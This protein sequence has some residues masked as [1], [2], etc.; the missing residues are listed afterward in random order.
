MLKIRSTAFNDGERIPKKYT[1]DGEDISPPLIWEDIPEGTVTLALI[2][3]DPD[4]P[5][6]TW[7]HWLIFNIPPELNG[8]PESVEKVGELENGI[9]QGFND[10]G[11]I[12]YGGPCPPF[13]VHRYFF[14]LYALDTSL[15]LEPGTSKEELLEAME[16]HIIEKT[17]MIGLYSRE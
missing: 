9:M 7:T 6:K 12:G 13:G 5:S 8:L 11:R 15:D 1:C 10:F 16:G 14:K 2:S 17:Q 3:D 4:A